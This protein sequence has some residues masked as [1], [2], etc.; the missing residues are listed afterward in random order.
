MSDTK[1]KPPMPFDQW[2]EQSTTAK[3]F[4]A[5]AWLHE[6][7]VRKAGK[8]DEATESLPDSEYAGIPYLTHLA[9]VFSIMLQA[10]HTTEQLVAALLHDAV[11]PPKDSPERARASE[12]SAELARTRLPALGFDDA[13]VTRIA[14]AVRDHSFS[15]GA[16]P[17]TVLGCALQDADLVRAE[18]HGRAVD[19]R[20]LGAGRGDQRDTDRRG[21]Q[22]RRVA[23]GPRREGC[24]WTSRLRELH[25]RSGTV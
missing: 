4:A 17:A 23:V 6:N 21:F 12:R 3:A 18:I 8:S 2:C 15:R 11:N 22:P 20:S 7:H 16:V 14:D 10:E 5:A 24:Q 25:G 19:D 13:A 9:D 1:H